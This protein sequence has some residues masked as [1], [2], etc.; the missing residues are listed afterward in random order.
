[1]RLYFWI[2]ERGKWVG[3]GTANIEMHGMTVVVLLTHSG[4]TYKDTVSA[5]GDKIANKVDKCF[6]SL[7]IYF[8]C[9]FI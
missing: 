8:L 9:L 4:R 5:V 1:M 2:H 7:F 6:V 3:T